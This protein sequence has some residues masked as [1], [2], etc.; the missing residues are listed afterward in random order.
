MNNALPILP[1]SV[2]Q[3]KYFTTSAISSPDFEHSFYIKI[4]SWTIYSAFNWFSV[5]QSLK[6]QVSPI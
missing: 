2:N 6:Y 1:S 5:S 4:H 3:S